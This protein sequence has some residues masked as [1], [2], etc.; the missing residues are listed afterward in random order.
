M[1]A[2]GRQQRVRTF[3]FDDPGNGFGIDGSTE[4]LTGG[5]RSTV[6]VEGSYVEDVDGFGASTAGGT[7]SLQRTVVREIGP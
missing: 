2:Q 5:G 3:F 1:S 7:L 6:S 4:V